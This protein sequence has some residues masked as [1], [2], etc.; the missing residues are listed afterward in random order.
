VAAD[1]SFADVFQDIL[2]NVQEIVRSEVRLAKAELREEGAKAVS[3]AVWVIAGTVA[4]LCALLFALWTMV[5]TLA[6]VWPLW[7]ATLVVAVVLAV[8]A[9]VLLIIGV[10]RLK[11]VHPTPERTVETIKENVAWIKQSTK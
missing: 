4:G 1:R 2:H 5:Y 7:A 11:R 8:T 3:S 6:L 9:S 10:G